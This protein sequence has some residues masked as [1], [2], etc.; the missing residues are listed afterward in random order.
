MRAI[1]LHLGNLKHIKDVTV[2]MYRKINQVYVPDKGDSWDMS[3]T[4]DIL[5]RA[6]KNGWKTSVSNI[7]T[8]LMNIE[9]DIT[10]LFQDDSMHRLETGELV[11]DM[12]KAV[13]RKKDD[14]SY[15]TDI[16]IEYYHSLK[17]DLGPWER[18]DEDSHEVR[19][20]KWACEDMILDCKDN[21]DKLHV[22]KHILEEINWSSRE[23]R[24]DCASLIPWMIL[25]DDMRDVTM[26]MDD[27]YSHVMSQ[28]TTDQFNLY[29]EGYSEG[30]HIVLITPHKRDLN[31][32][33]PFTMI[34]D[35]Q[36]FEIPYKHF[37]RMNERIQYHK[38]YLEYLFKD[39][40][41]RK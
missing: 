16:I 33:I 19:M 9:S 28:E 12:Y 41:E 14:K 10:A 20:I 24:A 27:P 11:P 34:K 7:C 35:G 2:P 40:K 1:Q 18:I 31:M 29:L 32:Y 4:G 38:E 26:W 8:E 15:S 5:F 17:G 25:D 3:M 23:F 30:N 37:D 22:P 13:M 6:I 36:S 39:R 21:G